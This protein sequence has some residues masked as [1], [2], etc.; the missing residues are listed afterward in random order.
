MTTQHYLRSFIDVGGVYYLSNYGSEFLPAQ[1]QEAPV[2]AWSEHRCYAPAEIGR[3]PIDPPSSQ[4]WMERI[5][6][7]D[8]L[9]R[10]VASGAGAHAVTMTAGAS[11]ENTKQGEAM[12]RLPC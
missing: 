10:R 11:G 3:I 12:S 7:H 1:S 2:D 6:G 8:N 4:W 5:P 9:W